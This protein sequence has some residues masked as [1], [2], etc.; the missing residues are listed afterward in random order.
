MNLRRAWDQIERE[1]LLGISSESQRET[2]SFVKKE[3]A[4]M[5]PLPK[6]EEEEK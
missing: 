4:A 2:T 3:E 5:T 6:L 1:L